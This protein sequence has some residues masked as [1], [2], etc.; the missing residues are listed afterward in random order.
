[1]ALALAQDRI[2]LADFTLAQIA[3]PEIRQLLPLTTM[4][5][6]SRAEELAATG[7]RLPHQVVIRLKD[8]TELKAERLHAKGSIA[9][10]FDDDDRAAKFADCC[11]RL[12]SDTTAAL[13]GALIRLDAQPGLDFLAPVFA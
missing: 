7:E 2:G 6:R 8:G 3:R 5:A 10:P 11:V 4:T 12:G 9:D 13:Y 1:V